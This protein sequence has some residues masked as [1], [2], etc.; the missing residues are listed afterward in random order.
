MNVFL[1]KVFDPPN[2]LAKQYIALPIYHTELCYHI[3]SEA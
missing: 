3:S 1:N 2:L